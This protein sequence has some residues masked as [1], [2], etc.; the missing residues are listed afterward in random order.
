MARESSLFR[1]PEFLAALI[2][3]A[4]AATGFALY[5][6]LSGRGPVSLTSSDVYS[7]AVTGTWQR[8]NP[9][10]A[11][12]NE[13][14]ADLS[15]L[16]FSG[17]LRLGPDGHLQPDLAELPQLSD[18]ERTYTF[19]LRKNVTWTDGKPLTAAD[20]EF[21][22]RRLTSPNFRGDQ[23]LAE[24]WLGVEVDA[25]APDTVVIRLKQASAPFLA[26]NAT[27]G[28]LPEHLLGTLSDSEI[29]DAPFNAQP[30][31]SGPFKIV[32]LDSREARLVA[33]QGY[34]LG[35]PELTEIRLRFFPDYSSAL[36]ALQSGDVNGFMPRDTLL[37][38]QI[39]ELRKAPGVKVDDRTRSVYN[40]LYLNNAQAAL[41][42]DPLV[43]R[44]LNM[45]VDRESLA[46]RVFGGAA[47][48]SSS[49]VTPG[50]WAYAEAH[51]TTRADVV[52]A[53]RLLE[54]AGWKAHPTTGIL[55]KDGGEF[56]FTIRTD[57]DPARVLL[58]TEVAGQLEALGIRATVASTTFS[59]L[60]RDFLQERQYEAALA[61]WDQGADPDP[62]FGWHSS[63]LG[64]AGLN[65]AN[66]EDTVSDE[67]IAKGRTTNDVEV[68]KDA[69]QQFQD[70]WAERA[71]SLVLAYPR[72]LYA[73]ADSLKGITQGVLF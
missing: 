56:R 12:A 17:L 41:F 71:P 55:V 62:Y 63:Q 51:D 7:E 52:Q 27:L 60:R 68:R 61:G 33:N 4:V 43:R 16:V 47:S 18:E 59:V 46:N 1:R 53:K 24:G 29:F 45:A 42:Q 67:L 72:F 19:K 13:V 2:A 58:A 50:T 20:V 9:L 25:P 30:V 57:N 48:P 21:T 36:R 73:H 6:G 22:I 11:G 26:R 10:Y 35:S 40:V 66:F 28:I 39:S 64:T 3:L 65:L 15:Q 14:D 69:Y 34:H 44:A 8:V 37:P 31:G 23:S 32:S 54:E 49:P 5:L 70:V 38:A